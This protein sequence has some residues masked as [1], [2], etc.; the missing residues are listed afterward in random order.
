MP[1]APMLRGT[2]DGAGGR[3]TSRDE[4]TGADGICGVPLPR[5]R[6]R[7]G[8]R[9]GGCP[10]LRGPL[11][12]RDGDSHLPGLDAL[13]HGGPGGAPDRRALA[14]ALLRSVPRLAAL[15]RP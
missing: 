15:A 13:P 8:G 2:T 5:A 9:A 7:A 3:T 4:K 6:V 1:D 11:A 10:R 14:P 12:R